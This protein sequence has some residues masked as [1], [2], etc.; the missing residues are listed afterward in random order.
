MRFPRHSDSNNRT[1]TCIATIPESHS[2]IRFHTSKAY[3]NR[4]E[5]YLTRNHHTYFVPLRSENQEQQTNKM[6]KSLLL[7]L[8]GLLATT[9]QAQNPRTNEDGK[10]IDKEKLEKKDYTIDVTYMNPRRGPGR[11]LTDSYTLTVRH[12]SLLSYLPYVGE[13]Y[14]VPYGGGKALNFSAPISEY[15]A[16]PGKKE[17]TTVRIKVENEEDNYTYTLTI[18]PDGGTTINVQPTQRQS[19]SFN[20]EMRTNE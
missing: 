8:M 9:I 20:G 15:T 7:L 16:E 11:A 13:A 18:F 2:L 4:N 3:C 10:Q 12:D 1:F 14:T 5:T 6:K 17:R 19:I